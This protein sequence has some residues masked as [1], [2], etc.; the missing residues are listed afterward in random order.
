MEKLAFCSHVAV[1]FIAAISS[2]SWGSRQAYAAQGQSPTA[3]DSL[4]VVLAEALNRSDLDIADRILQTQ[5]KLDSNAIQWQ[6]FRG[7]RS[8]IEI[9]NDKS[10]QNEE[11]LNRLRVAMERVVEI[12]EI[13]LEKN[14]S[15]SVALFYT[16]GAYGY[17]GIAQLQSGSMFKAGST[18]KKGFKLH[19][20]LIELCPAYYDAYLGPGMKNLMVSAIPWFLKPL[21]F[22]LGLTG[23]EET[24]KEYL[25]IAY[26]KGRSVHLEAGNYLAQVYE[27]RKEWGKSSAIYAELLGR[28]LYRAGL[29]AQSLQPLYAENKYEEAAERCKRMMERFERD[30]HVF[31]RADSVWMRYVVRSRC[32]ALKHL[33]K[34]GEAVELYH[35]VLRNKSYE[36]LGKWFFHWMLG[37]LHQDDRRYLEAKECYQKALLDVPEDFRK[38]IQKALDNLPSMP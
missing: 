27:R 37:R 17:L 32:S 1:L 15:D 35:Q 24:A 23:N 10:R 16:G 7:M 29:C 38:D 30:G 8:F 13:R 5:L 31:T 20:K 12:G 3:G 33:G 22:L 26:E 14:P 28:Y 11:N 34:G 36:R 21:L 2:L 4:E 25:T 18:A 6:F 19:E 9:S